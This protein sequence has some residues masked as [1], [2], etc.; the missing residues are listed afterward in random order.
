[1]NTPTPRTDA[2]QFWDRSD[3]HDPS[4]FDWFVRAE[5]ARTLERELNAEQ[6]E[7]HKLA[8]AEGDGPVSN[9]TAHAYLNAIPADKTAEAIYALAIVRGLRERIRELEKL[10]RIGELAIAAQKSTD[11]YCNESTIQ[12]S[13]E[14]WRIDGTEEHKLWNAM[15]SDIAALRAAI[16]AAIRE[17]A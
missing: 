8:R 17:G 7:A 16:D 9:N 1:M 2:A 3:Y 4:A 6:S 13:E 14:D 11:Y 12:P 10:A 15:E 5:H